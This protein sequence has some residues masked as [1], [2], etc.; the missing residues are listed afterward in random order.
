MAERAQNRT[1]IN[2][3]NLIAVFG[4]SIAI[5][6]GLLLAA[7]LLVAHPAL[8]GVFGGLLTVWLA[9]RVWPPFS[10]KRDG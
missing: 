6:L 1:K 9:G 2:Y 3:S 7:K 4:A 10:V 8:T 5:S